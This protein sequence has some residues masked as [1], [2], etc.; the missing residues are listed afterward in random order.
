MNHPNQHALSLRT[1]PSSRCVFTP[2]WSVP[3]YL[4]IWKS[5][6]FFPLSRPWALA[7]PLLPPLPPSSN[8]VVPTAFST[9][10]QFLLIT[11]LAPVLWFPLSLG[12]LVLVSSHTYLTD[13]CVPSQKRAAAGAA[14]D[15]QGFQVSLWL[16]YHA[17]HA[18]ET[19]GG[20]D[21]WHP[22][23]SNRSLCFHLYMSESDAGKRAH[24]Q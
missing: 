21:S 22:S 4:T 3:L 11:S 5:S 2:L 23:L 10:L 16:W 18:T 19:R 7:P 13:G 6:L 14:H 17:N 8:L 20:T 12:L 15:I 9:A 1:L 24:Q